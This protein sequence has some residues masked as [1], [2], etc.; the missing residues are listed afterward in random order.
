M[1]WYTETWRGRPR[2]ERQVLQPQAKEDQ[3]LLGATGHREKGVEWNSPSELL[4]GINH[5][6]F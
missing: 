6:T 1:I 5:S 4:T 3:R 2:E